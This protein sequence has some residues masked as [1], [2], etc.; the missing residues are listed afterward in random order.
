MA[1]GQRLLWNQGITDQVHRQTFHHPLV[2]RGGWR[3]ADPHP[4]ILVRITAATFR[5]WYER[6]QAQVQQVMAVCYLYL[7][8]LPLPILAQTAPISPSRCLPLALNR[9]H[10]LQVAPFLRDYS[11]SVQRLNAL[12]HLLL[13]SP[14]MPILHYH[15]RLVVRTCLPQQARAHKMATGRHLTLAMACRRTLDQAKPLLS[16]AAP[17]TALPIPTQRI[18]GTCR[19]QVLTR[20]WP[21]YPVVKTV[22]RQGTAATPTLQILYGVRRSRRQHHNKYRPRCRLLRSRS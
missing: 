1:G 9:H 10:L 19:S 7:P 21:P 15:P 14:H 22:P 4:Y 2:W 17:S 6:V 11:L 3:M 5:V 20:R 16:P 18:T 12:A 8:P 13:K